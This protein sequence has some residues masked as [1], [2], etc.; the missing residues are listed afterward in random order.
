[1]PI[2]NSHLVDPYLCPLCHEEFPIFHG[3][4]MMDD[5]IAVPPGFDPSSEQCSRSLLIDDH[6]GLHYISNT[7]GVVIILSGKSYHPI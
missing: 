5:H 3:W 7:L 6:M 1:M 4:R 2:Y